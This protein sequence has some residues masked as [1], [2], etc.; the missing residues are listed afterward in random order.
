MNERPK[1]RIK[2]NLNSGRVSPFEGNRPRIYFS[3]AYFLTTQPRK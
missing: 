1:G 2:E 3:S